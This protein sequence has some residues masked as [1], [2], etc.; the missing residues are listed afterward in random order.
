MLKPTIGLSR[1]WKSPYRLGSIAKGLGPDFSV[2][3]L[4]SE[5]LPVSHLS[6]KSGLKLLFN[7]SHRDVQEIKPKYP[8]KYK[9]LLVDRLLRHLSHLKH[10][11]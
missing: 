2:V 11:A 3:F 6:E 10:I 5:V 9:I 8:K 4:C 1:F 7:T